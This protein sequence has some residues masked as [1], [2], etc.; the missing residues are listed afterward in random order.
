[1]QCN[2]DYNS[3]NEP[4]ERWSHSTQ[5]HPNVAWF[6][7]KSSQAARWGVEAFSHQESSRAI[8]TPRFSGRRMDQPV[9]SI[10]AEAVRLETTDP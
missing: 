1:M 9:S 10:L 2:S 7:C 4:L 3:V 8:P 6:E 5:E